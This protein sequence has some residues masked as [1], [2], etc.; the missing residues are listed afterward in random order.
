MYSILTSIVDDGAYVRF[1][2][3]HPESDSGHDA[4]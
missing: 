2:D 1:I 4:L 3:A